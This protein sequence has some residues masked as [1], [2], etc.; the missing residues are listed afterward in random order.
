MPIRGTTFIETLV[1][2]GRPT[3]DRGFETHPLFRCSFYAVSALCCPI[4][5]AAFRRA[6]F[7]SKVLYVV[8]EIILWLLTYFKQHSSSWEA[9]R[10]L[11]SEEIPRILWNP[12]VYY[13]IH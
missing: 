9:N 10:F 1:A 8:Y 4:Q 13:H 11:A 2:S 6:D 12:E 5:V 3:T 7:P